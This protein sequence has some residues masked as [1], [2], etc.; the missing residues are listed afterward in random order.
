[1]YCPFFSL[2]NAVC[3][4]ILTY[5]VPVLF[6]FYIQSVLKFKKNNSGAKR[7]TSKSYW[8]FTTFSL[9]IKGHRKRDLR[10]RLCRH[11]AKDGNGNTGK[12]TDVPWIPT[13]PINSPPFALLLPSFLHVIVSCLRTYIKTYAR[14]LYA[15]TKHVIIDVTAVNVER[16]LDQISYHVIWD[17]ELL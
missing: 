8:K 16:W 13:F 1:M 6:I 5:L 9:T 15:V 10:F 3:F 2:Q 17:A 4:I 12:R 11:K 7:L 14:T